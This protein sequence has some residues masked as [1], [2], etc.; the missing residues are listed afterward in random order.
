MRK[1][2]ITMTDE[3]FNNLYYLVVKA[4]NLRIRPAVKVLNMLDRE[5]GRGA[6]WVDEGEPVSPEDEPQ[7]PPEEPQ[8]PP[9]PRHEGMR[10]I[11]GRRRSKDS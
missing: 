1:V 11:R 9:G 6:N 4:R 2:V 3:E 5:A 7:E 8:E 10:P